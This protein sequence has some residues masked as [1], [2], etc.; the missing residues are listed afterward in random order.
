MKI[1]IEITEETAA[2]M[3]ANSWGEKGVAEIV[4]R[5]AEEHA[6]AYRRAFPGAV[7][8]AVEDF[9][10]SQSIEHPPLRKPAEWEKETG[11]IVMDYGGWRD[12]EYDI[13]IT[14][15]EFLGR[16]CSSRC[17]IPRDIMNEM[18]GKASPTK[19]SP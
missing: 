6:E 7:E 8:K 10:G 11:V 2:L 18:T 9:R 3:V 12:K 19:E 16:C 14:R 13:A 15:E 4:K 17:S 5:L 1:E